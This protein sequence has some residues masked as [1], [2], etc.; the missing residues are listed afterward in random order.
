MYDRYQ[1]LLAAFARAN[2]L[3]ADMLTQTQ[4][5]ELDGLSVGLAFEGE[6]GEADLVCFCD[7]GQPLPE[8]AAEVFKDML[9]ANHFWLG[10]G[11]ATLGLQS[12]TGNV[13]L[14]LRTPLA[15]LGIEG[16]AALLKLFTKV[17]SF[18]ARHLRSDTG[19][20]SGVLH[21]PAVAL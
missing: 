14:A 13:M 12:A 1:D 18:W 5:F 8:R 17:A 3:D 21:F 11:G 16:L 15:V 19:Q 9:E 7:L 4:A 20:G 2:Q 6:G 10:T